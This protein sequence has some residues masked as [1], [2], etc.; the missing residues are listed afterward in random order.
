M[1]RRSGRS[2]SEFGLRVEAVA[3]GP[4]AIDAC[5]VACEAG[6]P[7]DLVILD[8]T[9]AGGIGGVETLERIRTIQPSIRALATSGYTS[10]RVMT[11]PQRHSFQASLAKPFLVD[12]LH[13]VVTS[14][15][16]D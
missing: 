7:Y 11:E 13:K 3:D 12:E 15:L 9:I 5:R 1:R 4:T 10:D 14:L 8:L 6:E 16:A 2:S